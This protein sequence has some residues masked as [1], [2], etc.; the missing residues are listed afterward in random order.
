[1]LFE[2]YHPSDPKFLCRF[3]IPLTV[4]EIAFTALILFFFKFWIFENICY[5]PL[6]TLVIPNFWSRRPFWFFENICYL[7]LITLVIPNFDL[8]ALSLTVTE[9][10]FLVKSEPFYLANILFGK[11]HLA[12]FIWRNFILRTSFGEASFS[13][14]HLAWISCANPFSCSETFL[15]LALPGYFSLKS[16]TVI[17]WELGIIYIR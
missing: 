11:L 5:L 13:E 1:M 16:V 8:F 7:T 6:I 4:T 10:E 12:N 15:S 3:A 9:I 2:S 14:L 17:E